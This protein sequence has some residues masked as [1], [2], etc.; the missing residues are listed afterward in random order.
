[1][2][3]VIEKKWPDHMGKVVREELSALKVARLSTTIF[4]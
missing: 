4:V 2:A 3:Q 1:M